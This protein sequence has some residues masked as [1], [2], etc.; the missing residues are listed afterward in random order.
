MVNWFDLARPKKRHLQFVVLSRVFK[1]Q[2]FIPFCMLSP[3]ITVVIDILFCVIIVIKMITICC[4]T[5]LATFIFWSLIFLSFIFVDPNLAWFCSIRSSLTLTK[6]GVSFE[7]C[8][9]SLNFWG[10][11]SWSIFHNL[12]TTSFPLLHTFVSCIFVSIDRKVLKNVDQIVSRYLL[13][14]KFIL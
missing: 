8:S 3:K 6:V 11:S 9:W 12:S 10:W 1:F 13:V 2:I 5:D 14:P 7:L 4:D